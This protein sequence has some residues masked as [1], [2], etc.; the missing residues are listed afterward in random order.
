M[1]LLRIR[2]FQVLHVI[3]IAA[4]CTD[5]PAQEKKPQLF[6]GKVI[7]SN[8]KSPVSF[9]MVLNPTSKNNTF[10]DTSGYFSLPVFEGDT[11]VISRIGFH[12]KEIRIS[13]ELLNLRSIHMIEMNQRS[14]DLNAI[15][16]S[17][18]G[19]YE[20][21]RY[22]IIHADT[23]DELQINPEITRAFNNK[24]TV[25]E[26]QAK[27]S[28]G[29]P[30]TTLYNLLSKEGKS[31]RKLD[32]EEAKQREADSYKDKYSPE[33][34]SRLTGLKELE[35]EKFMKYCSPDVNFIKNSTEY[36]IAAKILECFNR[37]KAEQDS[38]SRLQK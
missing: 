17:S 30:I 11:L 28:L 32:K 33:V 19:T 23:D 25:L 27:I 38:V 20:Q 18:P 26:P 6:M 21:F 31:L 5:L 8:D 7:S 35:L 15:S 16:L 36:D 14:Y 4:I 10:S 13:K 37:Y 2:N 34:V 24:V 29:S 22:N 3:L 12:P 1:D 9:A